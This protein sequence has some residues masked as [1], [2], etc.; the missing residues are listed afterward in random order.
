MRVLS[1]Y[2]ADVPIGASIS[3]GGFFYETELIIFWSDRYEP[4]EDEL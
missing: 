2:V 3:Y 1:S 4:I